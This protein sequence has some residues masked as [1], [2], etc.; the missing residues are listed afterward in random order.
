[1]KEPTATFSP[2]FGNAFLLLHPTAYGKVL[3]KQMKKHDCQAWL[4]N[5]GWTGG[6]PG[7]G[8]RMSLKPTRR[9]IDAIVDG[10]LAKAKFEKFPVFNFEIPTAVDGVEPAILN[11]RNTWTDKKAYDDTLKKL[12]GMFAEKFKRFA[13]NDAGKE[14]LKVGPQI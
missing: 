10:T 1:M 9:I 14:L 2:C 4:V 8:K 12:A 7:V 3:A 6:G 11:P 5:T 13:D